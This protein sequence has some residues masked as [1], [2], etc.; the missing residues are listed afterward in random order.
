MK[1][2]IPVPT[3]TSDSPFGQTKVCVRP[4][5]RN[6]DTQNQTNQRRIEI[7]GSADLQCRKV[8][9][10]KSERVSADPLKIGLITQERAKLMSNQQIETKRTQIFPV[11]LNHIYS[12]TSRILKL[13]ACFN[14]FG[15]DRPPAVPL[16]HVCL[17]TWFFHSV[18]P[19][20][21]LLLV[22]RLAP[23]TRHVTFL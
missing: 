3:Y 6:T 11:N 20:L 14:V 16:F 15:N 23:P 9:I 8:N 13:G 12:V 5:A 17:Q 1:I 18:P 4:I 19:S 21:I 7:L 22:Y 2:K 10:T